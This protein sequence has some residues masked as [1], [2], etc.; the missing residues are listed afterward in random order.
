MF[1]LVRASAMAVVVASAFLGCGGDDGPEELRKDFLGTYAVNAFGSVTFSGQTFALPSFSGEQLIFAGT[2]E[3]EIVFDD[4]DCAIS[5]TVTSKT[6][7]TVHPRSCVVAT[8]D[9][10]T[11]LLQVQNGGGTLNGRALTVNYSGPATVTCPDGTATGTFEA[12]ATGT[13]K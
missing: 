1:N 13:K 2:K 5:A 11:V 7:F 9:G 3:N 4:E 6:A 10:C 8:D 12:H